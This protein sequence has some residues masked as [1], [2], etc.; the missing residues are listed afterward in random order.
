MTDKT[1]T[2]STSERPIEWPAEYAPEA[3]TVFVSNEIVIA[4]P[5]ERI[6]PWL[7][8]A[9][10]WPTWYSNSSD[11]HYLSHAGPDLRNRS[12]FRWKTFG[13]RVTSKVLE[14]EPCRRMAWDAH[15]I[16]LDAYHA[17]VLTPLQ[18]GSTHVLTEE[19]QKGWLAAV[20]NRL[21]PSRIKTMHQMWLNGLS[22]QAQSGLPG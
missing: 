10:A 11:I 8:R 6:W 1:A 4:A 9:E 2:V 22:R 5:A 15:G 18:D 3:S 20:G 17:W 19:T 7:V 12:R 13:L 21:M 14:F 16:G